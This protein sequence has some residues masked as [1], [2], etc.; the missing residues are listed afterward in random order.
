[1]EIDKDTKVQ[2]N[3]IYSPDTCVV[4]THRTNMV[5]VVGRQSRRKTEKLKLTP[6]DVQNIVRQKNSGEFSSQLAKEYNVDHSTI[7]RVFRQNQP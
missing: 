4:V 7:N 1:M 2:G 3:K 5:A 6:E